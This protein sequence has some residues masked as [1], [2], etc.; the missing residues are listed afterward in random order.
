MGKR[1]YLTSKMKTEIVLSLLRGEAI[2]LLSRKYEV[3]VADISKWR[4]AFLESGE[5]AFKRSSEDSKLKEAERLLGR[6]Q[7]E[8]EL[9]KKKNEL[10]QKRSGKS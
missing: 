2:E 5:N 7:M 8:L 3:T 9:T 10:I 4:D 6:L 1:N